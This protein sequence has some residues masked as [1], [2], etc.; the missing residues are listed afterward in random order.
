MSATETLATVA[1][2]RE[3]QQEHGIAAL[4]IEHDMTFVRRLDCPVTVM[5]RG[6]VLFEGSYA[7]VQAHPEVREAYL[8]HAARA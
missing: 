8:G 1:L 3:L 2:I 4:V 7:Q 5:L 6:S